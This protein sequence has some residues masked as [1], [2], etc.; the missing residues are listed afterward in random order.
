[1]QLKFVEF[2][3]QVVRPGSY[4]ILRALKNG[5]KTW[6][7]LEKIENMNSAKLKRRL[8]DLL[9]NNLIEVEVIFNKPTGSKAYKL[10][11]LGLKILEKLEEIEKIYEEEM[12]KAPPKEPEEFLKGRNKL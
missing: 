1:M 5:P 8:E 9:G 10:T 11:P 12:K 2:I 3:T 7:E 4:E 6:S